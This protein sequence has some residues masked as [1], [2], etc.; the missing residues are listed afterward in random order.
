MVSVCDA[1]LYGFYLDL[2]MGVDL[3]RDL[4]NF[5]QWSSV[6]SE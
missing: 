3:I 1:K 4:I 5:F 6:Y 2:Y